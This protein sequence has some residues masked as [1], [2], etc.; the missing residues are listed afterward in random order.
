M[1]KWDQRCFAVIQN[2]W[3]SFLLSIPSRSFSPWVSHS[4]PSRPS[5]VNGTKGAYP[6]CVLFVESTFP[7]CVGYCLVL[8]IPPTASAMQG[9]LVTH[10]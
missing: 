6:S 5:L 8:I 1:R 2:F 10:C 3:A 7:L 9:E 4:K